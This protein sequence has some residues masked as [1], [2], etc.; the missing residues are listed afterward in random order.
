MGTPGK[1]G[2]PGDPGL[3][4]MKGKASPRGELRACAGLVQGRSWGHIP[5]GVTAHYSKKA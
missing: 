5:S 2:P 1:V 3:P 4:G